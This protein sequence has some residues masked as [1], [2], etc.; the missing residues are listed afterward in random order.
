MTKRKRQKI[1]NAK[2]FVVKITLPLGFI[3]LFLWLLF[4]AIY[5]KK[6]DIQIFPEN[7]KQ[8]DT[9][10]IRVREKNGNI[11]GDF[12]GKKLVFLKLNYY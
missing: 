10:L 4:F 1:K 7:P 9:V 5:Q 12:D 6:P 11:S 2:N 8:G 3:V